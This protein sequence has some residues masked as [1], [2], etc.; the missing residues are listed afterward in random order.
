MCF[1]AVTAL[2]LR[3]S[4]LFRKNHPDSFKLKSFLFH[5][6]EFTGKKVFHYLSVRT[7]RNSDSG[8]K[9]NESQKKM[10]FLPEPYNHFRRV[11]PSIFCSAEIFKRIGLHN[12]TI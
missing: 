4:L 5:F 9:M 12:A 10:P 11:I 8:C 3:L 7:V 2:L 1:E 6:Q